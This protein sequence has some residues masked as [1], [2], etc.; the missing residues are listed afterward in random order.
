MADPRTLEQIAEQIN[1]FDDR[2][3]EFLRYAV[4]EGAY[5]GD[6]YDA[7]ADC[8]TNIVVT[9]GELRKLSALV[10]ALRSASEESEQAVLAIMVAL[11]PLVADAAIVGKTYGWREVLTVVEAAAAKLRS[12]SAPQGWPIKAAFVAGWESGHYDGGEHDC[13]M[14]EPTAERAWEDYLADPPAAAP[15]PHTEKEE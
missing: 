13:R 1:E 5:V 2:S 15:A 9:R 8:E 7:P 11:G 6:I 3:L 12:A 10:A 4:K 14:F